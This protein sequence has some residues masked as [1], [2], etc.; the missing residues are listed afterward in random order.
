MLKD[1]IS[2]KMLLPEEEQ[3][4]ERYSAVGNY[5]L[6]YGKTGHALLC[7]LLSEASGNEA[8]AMKARELLN[9]VSEN[10]ADVPVEGFANGLTG[11]G[12]GIEWL[13]R[14]QY[15][16]V[17]TNEILDDIDDAVYRSI[18]YKKTTRLSLSDGM[19]GTA[20]YIYK[21]YTARNKSTKRFRHLCLQ[22]CLVLLTARITEL[23]HPQIQEAMYATALPPDN[24]AMITQSIVF[25]LKMI[26]H[27]INI[28]LM[29][30]GVAD[31]AKLIEHLLENVHCDNNTRLQ[32]Y[33]VYALAA[34]HLNNHRMKKFVSAYNISHYHKNTSGL[35]ITSHYLLKKYLEQD[36]SGASYS[37]PTLLCGANNIPE[38]LSRLYTLSLIPE[39]SWDEALLLS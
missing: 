36:A 17:D 26:R 10:I 33:Y 20:L 16:D 2:S 3:Q 11:I 30:T 37:A 38:Q 25:M 29:E 1:I 4:N 27:S 32:L 28:S 35:H 9:E 24:A 21:R 19:L 34:N 12:W 23:L 15:I 39:S 5:G 8:L 14:Q 22:E 13:A 31:M 18:I 7:F 6:Y